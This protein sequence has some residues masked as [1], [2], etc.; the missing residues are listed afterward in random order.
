M[1]HGNDPRSLG[2]VNSS[3][4]RSQPLVLLVSRIGFPIIVV[5][6]TKWSTIGGEGLDFRW[7]GL[8]TFKVSEER[9]FRAVGIVGLAVNGDKVGKTV[10]EGIPEISNTTSF[11]ARHLEAIDVGSK[12]SSDVSFCTYKVVS[13]F[14]GNIIYLWEGG[15]L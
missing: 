10:I 6:R 8:I 2:T 4:I 9:I 11:I 13:R 7:M 1:A 3:K 14:E 5:D 12:V 15:Q